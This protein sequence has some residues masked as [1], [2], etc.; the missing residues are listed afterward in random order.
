VL[1]DSALPMAVA[2]WPKVDRKGKGWAIDA[3]EQAGPFRIIEIVDPAPSGSVNKASRSS[4]STGSSANPPPVTTI[5]DDETMGFTLDLIA[6]P[7]SI[8][9]R[10]A[11]DSDITSSAIQA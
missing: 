9:K 2:I 4:S 11:S 5:S 3:Y 8:L 6:P 1:T 7:K 10:C